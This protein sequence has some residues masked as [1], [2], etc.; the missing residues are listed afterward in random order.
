MSFV[1]PVGLAFRG[2]RKFEASPHSQ[3]TPDLQQSQSF[4][5]IKEQRIEFLN[6]FF[7]DNVTVFLQKLL[8]VVE[9]EKAR[10]V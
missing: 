3:S 9:T 1:P 6:L 8:V 2:R 10:D 5:A 7:S 4:V